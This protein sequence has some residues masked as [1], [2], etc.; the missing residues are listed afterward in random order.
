MNYVKSFF[1]L[2]IGFLAGVILPGYVR[3]PICKDTTT[4]DKAFAEKKVPSMKIDQAFGKNN[5]VDVAIIGSGPAGLSSALYASRFARKT[6]VIAGNNQG[7][8]LMGTS[9]VENWPGIEKILGPDLIE[10][11]RAQAA[12]FGP[13]FLADAVE[14]VDFSMW[15]FV[16]N[17]ENGLKIHALSVIIATGA[18]PKKLGIPGEQEYWGRGVT[19][20]AICDAPFYKGEEVVVVGG[21]DSAVEEAIQLA[22]YV[23]KVTMLVRSSKMRATPVMQK[24]VA[25]YPNIEIR[26]NTAIEKIVGDDVHVTGIEVIDTATKQKSHMSISGVFLAIGHEP[27][28]KPFSS[29]IDT[30]ETG[31]IVIKDRS[32]QTS[33]PGIFAAGDV[34]DDVYRQGGVAAGNGIK[35]AIDADRFLAALGLDKQVEEKLAPLYFKVQKQEAKELQKIETLQEYEAALGDGKLPVI[36][37]FYTD[38]CPSC[39]QMLPILASVAQDYAGKA[40]FYK[41]NAELAEDLVDKFSV[42]RVPC[43]I[44]IKDGALVARYNEAMGKKELVELVEKI[45]Q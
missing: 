34:E 44:V 5:I 40:K 12:S 41:V 42:F 43:L 22:P 37:D 18:S 27:N 20:C 15:P 6:V 16:I 38:T 26:Y 45:I 31:Y 35:A 7:G 29:F 14:S 36:L 24:R 1:I 32:Q 23:K 9:Y 39:L 13:Q 11:L 10:K 28:S 30:D 17:T 2:G 21:G 25:G 33:V 3:Q 19:T 4:H 8:Q